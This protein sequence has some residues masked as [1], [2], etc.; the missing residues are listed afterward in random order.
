MPYSLL[1]F[2]YDEVRKYIIRQN[3]GGNMHFHCISKHICYPSKKLH[4]NGKGDL[5][6]HLFAVIHSFKRS[7]MN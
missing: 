7:R 1:I 6:S 2:I 5:H 3:P 4:F